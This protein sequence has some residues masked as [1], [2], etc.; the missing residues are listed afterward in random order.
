MAELPHLAERPPP[1]FLFVRDLSRVSRS[2]FSAAI[3][4][5]EMGVVK[6]QWNGSG[7][8]DHSVKG[9]ALHPP[10]GRMTRTVVDSSVKAIELPQ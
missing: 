9:I 8:C 2:A 6:A 3:S 4:T 7:Y 1:L 5:A 10:S